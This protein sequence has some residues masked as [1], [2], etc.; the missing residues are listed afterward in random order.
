MA[1][2]LPIPASLNLPKERHPKA[3]AAQRM[4]RQA[5][6]YRRTAE[7]ISEPELR[8][9]FMAKAKAA[10]DEA[11]EIRRGDQWRVT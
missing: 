10:E 11:E 6:E 5:D 7:G 9:H 4:E 8:Q 1:A 3:P 2:G